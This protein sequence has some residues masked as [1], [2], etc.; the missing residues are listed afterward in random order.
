MTITKNGAGNMK[1]QVT[2]VFCEKCGK[3]TYFS[4]EKFPLD[5]KE[6]KAKLEEDFY[7]NFNSRLAT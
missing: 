1:I 3:P 6:V 5:W 2:H 7:P 4:I